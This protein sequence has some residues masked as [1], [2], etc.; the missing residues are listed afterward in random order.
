MIQFIIDKVYNDSL[1]SNYDKTITNKQKA[2]ACI[3]LYNNTTFEGWSLGYEYP[4]LVEILENM[5]QRIKTQQKIT[6]AQG[7]PKLTLDDE[8]R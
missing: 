7:I 8:V 2:K 6:N 4:E 5:V 1:Y 3:Y